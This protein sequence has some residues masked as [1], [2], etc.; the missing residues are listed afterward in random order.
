[1]WSS[2]K[3]SS[4]QN[5]QHK[6]KANRIVFFKSINCIFYYFLQLYTF[7][8]F[9]QFEFCFKIIQQITIIFS[10]IFIIFSITLYFF[11]ISFYFGEIAK[12]QI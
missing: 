6:N 12:N 1:M 2:F 8:N 3:G 11:V 9:E 5:N 7:N 10:Q 4:K